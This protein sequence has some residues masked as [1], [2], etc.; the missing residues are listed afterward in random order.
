MTKEQ[1]QE[2]LINFSNHRILLWPAL[3][4]TKHLKLPVMEL[5]CGY[6]STPY[7]Q[8]YCMEAGIPFL[9]YDSNREW[10]HRMGS[11]HVP[12]WERHRFNLNYSVVLIDEAPGGHR[13]ESIRILRGQVKILVA[14]DTEIAADHGYQMRAELF[15]WKY[16]KEYVTDGAG[17][18]AVSDE[19]DVSKW[20]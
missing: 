15:K 11:V 17:C 18:M 19:I 12:K 16:H 4:A 8:T 5:G 13:K 7:L 10:A 3:E 14:H 9:S 6:G 2:G 1:F 20:V